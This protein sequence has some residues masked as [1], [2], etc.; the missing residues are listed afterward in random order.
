MD[1]LLARLFKLQQEHMANGERAGQA[2]FNAL[3]SIDPQ[4][5]LKITGDYADCF[6]DNSRIPEFFAAVLNDYLEKNP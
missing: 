2:L 6:Y 5:A 4:L 3:N 1:K